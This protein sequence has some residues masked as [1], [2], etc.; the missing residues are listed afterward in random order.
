ML[1]IKVFA[2][3]EQIEEIA[4]QNTGVSV[5]GKHIYAVQRPLYLRGRTI[6]HKRTDGWKPLVR[7]VLDWIKGKEGIDE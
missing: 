2:N 3:Q 6:M 5:N 4:I 7:Q 1:V